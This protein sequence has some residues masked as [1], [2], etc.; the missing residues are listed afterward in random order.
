MM[1]NFLD[2]YFK[3]SSSLLKFEYF[4]SFSPTKRFYL[5]LLL[6]KKGILKCSLDNKAHDERLFRL[7][8]Q[9]LNQKKGSDKEKRRGEILFILR[10][11][12]MKPA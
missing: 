2:C 4:S 12:E 5:F 11:Q 1:R 3:C 10:H 8:L 9:K 7:R 6:E